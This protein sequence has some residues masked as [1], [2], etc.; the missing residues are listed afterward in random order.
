MD[1]VDLPNQYSWWSRLN[2]GGLLISPARLAHYFSTQTPDLS[3][4]WSDRLR[5]AVQ[6][7]QNAEKLGAEPVLLDTVLEGVLRL[8]ALE[9]KKASAVGAEWTYPLLTGEKLKPRRLWLGAN[10]A[11]LPVFDDEV[12]QIGM[13]SGRRSVAR[14]IEWLRKSQVKFALLTNGVQWRLIHAGPDYDAWCEWNIALWFEDGE[15]SEQVRALQ[16]LLSVRALTPPKEGEPA[17]LVASIQDTRKGQS[18]LSA[19]L[20]ER[21]RLAVEHLIHSSGEVIDHLRADSVDVS[22]RDVY[23]AAT[24][25]IMRCVV[26]LFAEA[27]E[28]LPRTDPIYNDSYS[29]QG[30]RGQL[31]RMAGGRSRDT[32]RDQWGAWP[33]LLSLFRLIYEG[34]SHEALIVRQYGG[35]LFQPGDNA[36]QDPVLRALALF[37]HPKNSPSDAS[38]H[39]IIEL[40]TRAWERVPQG[41][42]STLVLSSIDFSDLSTEYIGILYE[43]LLDFQ[44]RRA[45]SPIVFLN[46]GDQPA[47]PF[48]QLDAMPADEISKL[49]D[50]FKVAEKKG[51]SGEDD[52][53]EDTAEAEDVA[54]DVAAGPEGEEGEALAEI[55]IDEDLV[56]TGDS[57]QDREQLR[58][59]I[60]SW[61][62]RVAEI[63]KLAKKPKGK[64]TPEK[65]RAYEDQLDKAARALVPRTIF[66][67]EWYLVREGNTRKGSGTFYTRPQLAGPITRR[68]LRELVYEGET[69]R[70]PEE[71]LALKV[72]DPACGS[73]SFLLAALRFLTEALVESLYHHGRLEQSSEGAIIRLADGKAATKLRDETIPKPLDD[74]EFRDYL[75]AYLRRHIVERCLYGVDLDPLAIELGRLAL[76]IETMDPRLPFGFLDHK[77]KVGNALIGCWF[78]RFQ[79]YPAMAW[80]REGGDAGHERFVHHFR[81]STITKG[82]NAGEKK[83]KGDKWTQ[84]IKDKKERV[85]TELVQ[86]IRARRTMAFEFLEAQFTSVGVH[87]QLVGAFEQIHNV[88]IMDIDERKR[89]YEQHFGLGSAYR[90]LRTAFDT[91]CSIWFWPGDQLD[92]A[93]LPVDFLQPSAETQRVVLELSSVHRFFHWELEFPDVFQGGRSGFDACIGN[94]P[95]EVQKPN[96]KEFFSD[97][98]PLYRGYGKQ[99]A[100]DRQFEYFRNDAQVEQNWLTYCARLKARSN[101]VKYGAHPFGDQ[102]W[103]DNDKSAHHEF[104][105][106]KLFVQSAADHK[107]WADLRKG[108]SCFADPNHPFLHQGSADLNTY[109]MFLE[110]GHALLRDGGRLALLVPSGIYSDKGSAAL[111]S[112]FLKKSRW[113]H[114]YAF[115]NE[116][117]VF[118]AVHHSFKVA[119]IQVEKN[120]IPSS[121]RTRF[122]LG[123]GDSPEA[124]ELEADIP[125]EDSYLAVSGSEI[126]EFS[127]HSGAILEIRT[128]RDLEIVRKLY[129]NGVLLGDKSSKGWNLRYT[130]EFDMAS[131][132]GLFPPRWKWEEKGYLPDEYGHWLLGGWQLY[133]GP[134][135]IL[136]RPEGLIL[137]AD[138]TVAIKLDE[139]EDV[140]LPLYQGGM[141]NQFDFCASAY[142][143]MDGRRGFKWVPVDW[144]NKHLEPQ[145]LMSRATYQKDEGSVRGLKLVVRNIARTTDTRTFIGSLID[146]LPSGHSL[147]VMSSADSLLLCA[148]LDSFVS[149][150]ALRE[151][152]VGTNLSLFVIQDLVSPRREG[153]I[154]LKALAARLMLCHARFA[155]AWQ[156]DH[157]RSWYK[158]WA[159]TPHE[160]LRCRV[161]LEAVIAYLY[162]LT[163]TDFREI[164]SGSDHPSDRLRSKEFIRRLDTKGFWRYQKSSYPEHRLSVLSQVAL[165]E[166]CKMGFDNFLAQNDGE[167]WML[168]ESLRLSDYDLGHD[169]RAEEAQPVTAALGPRFYPWQLEQ[170]VE[171]SWKEC[172]R[173]AEILSKLLPPP[174]EDEIDPETG[175]AILVDLFGD[176][177]ETDLFGKA[178][179]SKSRRR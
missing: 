174:E 71:I 115:Q 172:A 126:E 157:R 117:F 135:S 88:P 143:K 37:E 14:V 98:D 131:D 7:Q 48:M 82:K 173:H 120:G 8:P 18:E 9:W 149:D 11:V 162:G 21:V 133:S 155:P 110:S 178:V 79:D 40:L 134:R 96:S 147:A 142:R 86:L 60:H 35:G 22:P 78:D 176:P 57:T 113:S 122:R 44:L 102:I 56:D 132:S 169:D 36:S 25:L 106:A 10:G 177:V 54:E 150:W 171:E 62:R 41:R 124:H 92:C 73:G 51:E 3:S 26:V 65:I 81:E 50:K 31:D 164:M 38:I 140:A 43:G 52:A 156:P 94:P 107:L 80:D 146:D 67:G 129:A 109:K 112:L 116:R 6:S 63:A 72:C 118:G 163:Q 161:V 84:A 74:P 1:H 70:K 167:G 87:D 153:L 30:L 123:P 20:G 139:I 137:S 105:L 39:Q 32:L 17:P 104:P 89:V 61:A 85:R 68:A 100:L 138:G 29:L 77:M 114:L 158:S 24:R 154:Q 148:V 42:S 175:D 159:L 64:L 4:Y 136:Q 90:E 127:P 97:V 16:H 58:Q 151:R 45:D 47:L 59:R 160:R 55:V 12:K 75:R 66:P 53:G 101:W 83:R 95:W 27:R 28:L 13:G 33:R 165:D 179:K 34:S 170:S 93:P 2:H 128:T 91:W 108:R 103:F 111:R 5:T 125:N 166:L 99:E 119:A 15:P 168:P 23:I 152:M 141:V 76:W 121:L 19:N 69:P 145:Y 49:F 46:I 130:R 144:D